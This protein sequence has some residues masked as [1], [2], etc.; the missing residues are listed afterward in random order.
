MISGNKGSGPLQTSGTVDGFQGDADS[1]ANG[2]Y[3]RASVPSRCEGG[4]LARDIGV[5]GEEA[6]EEDEED[7]KA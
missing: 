2:S 5:R 7:G 3:R 6:I 4:Q 1:M